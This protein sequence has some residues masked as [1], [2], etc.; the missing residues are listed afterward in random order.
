MK[1]FYLLIMSL[2]GYAAT[3]AQPLNGDCPGGLAIR[4]YQVN[5]TPSFYKLFITG[6]PTAAMTGSNPPASVTLRDITGT[7]IPIYAGG[8]TTVPFTYLEANGSATIEWDGTGIDYVEINYWIGDVFK[9]CKFRPIAGGAMPI[10]LSAFNGRLST[11][12]EATLTWTSSLEENSFQYEVQRSADGK[13]FTTVGTVKAAGTSLEAIKY[14]FKDPLPGTGGFFYRLNM[15]DIDDKTELSKVVYVNNKKGSD[16]IT[17]IFPNPFTSEVQ[18][19]GA[20]SADL[21]TPGNVRI[22]NMQGQLVNFRIVGA[23][24]I[25]I[26]PNAAKGVYFLKFRNSTNTMESTFKLIKQ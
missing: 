18:L 1:K 9:E 20:T 19:I 2:V 12:S 13:N 4:Y 22:F 16:I 10:K 7:P 21:N 24:A 6:G 25:A 3:F 11:E 14:S 8:G 15:R 26:D 17:K 23:N 5:I